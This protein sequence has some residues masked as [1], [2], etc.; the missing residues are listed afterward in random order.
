[1][2]V[3]QILNAQARQLFL[4]RTIKVLGASF[5]CFFGSVSLASEADVIGVSVEKTA[6]SLYDFSVTVFHKDSGWKHYANKWDILDS[7][8]KVL[9]TRILY[10]PH[11][12]EQP[13]TRGLSDVEISNHIK[14]VTVRAY[15]SKHGQGGK[16]MTVA[17][18]LK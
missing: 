8:G 12:N 1:M 18:P 15:D 13:F 16:E 6:D 2:F 9:A 14:S 5:L 10:H 7:H 3:Q 11:V 4:S 17:L